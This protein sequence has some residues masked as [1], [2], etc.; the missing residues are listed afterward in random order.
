MEFNFE[1]VTGICIVAFRSAKVR[2][3]GTV[4][5]FCVR[6]MFLNVAFR[7]AK[8][9]LIRGAKVTLGSAHSRSER[10]LWDTY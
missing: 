1:A 9:A 4:H 7:S 5:V 6:F 8:V 3:A 2:Q 10:R